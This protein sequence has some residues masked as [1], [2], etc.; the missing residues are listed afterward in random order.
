[1]ALFFFSSFYILYTYMHICVYVYLWIPAHRIHPVGYEANEKR[2][3]NLFGWWRNDQS[4]RSCPRIKSTKWSSFH[5]LK[6]M[7]PPHERRYFSQMYE[8]M[9][10]SQL[11]ALVPNFNFTQVTNICRRKSFVPYMLFS[12]SCFVPLLAAKNLDGVFFSNITSICLESLHL[13][14]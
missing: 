3:N 10:L 8:K 12:T 14:V 4:D 11:S 9:E 2:L 1:M 13:V 6:I 5:L 7:T